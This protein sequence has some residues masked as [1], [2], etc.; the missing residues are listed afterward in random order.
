M[1]LTNG[2]E[3]L[4]SG[5]CKYLIKPV[6]IDAIRATVSARLGSYGRIKAHTRLIFA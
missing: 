1:W 3:G 2:G 4:S 5:R 6:P